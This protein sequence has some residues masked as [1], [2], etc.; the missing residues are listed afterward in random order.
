M[1]S[2]KVPFVVIGEPVTAAESSAAGTAS[3]KATDDTVPAPAGRSAAT[4]ARNVGAT[5]PPLPGPAYTRFA[6]W[7]AL[8]TAIVPAPTTGELVTVNSFGMLS[9]T[10]VTDP[11]PAP[12]TVTG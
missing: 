4:S 11:D 1:V 6:F 5:A 10:D 8:V 2:P 12:P 9:P 3:V 7:T